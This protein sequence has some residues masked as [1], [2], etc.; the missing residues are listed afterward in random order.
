MAI[1]D[2]A[3]E[4]VYHVWDIIL[5]EFLGHTFVAGLRTLK[6]KKTFQKRKPNKNLKNLKKSKNLVT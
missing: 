2:A 3:G 5:R 4:R 6:H 1:N